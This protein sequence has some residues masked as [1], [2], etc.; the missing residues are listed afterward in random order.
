MLINNQIFKLMLNKITTY[1]NQLM[2]I[3][4][5]QQNQLLHT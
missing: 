5:L 4:L 1:S 2:T 3:Q